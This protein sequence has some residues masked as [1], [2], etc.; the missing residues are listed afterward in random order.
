MIGSSCDIFLSY[1]EIARKL[2][3]DCKFPRGFVGC[4]LKVLNTLNI[5]PLII[6]YMRDRIILVDIL[7]TQKNFPHIP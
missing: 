2:E 3:N 1:K 4:Y 5:H 7:T 6:W